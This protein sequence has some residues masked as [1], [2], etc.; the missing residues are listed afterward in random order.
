MEHLLEYELDDR[1]QITL[2]VPCPDFDTLSKKQ[3]RNKLT[4]N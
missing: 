3:A 4:I 1:N 2:C